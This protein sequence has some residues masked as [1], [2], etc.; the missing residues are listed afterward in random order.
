M[1]L[2]ARKRMMNLRNKVVKMF[3]LC[4]MEPVSHL[5]VTL[6]E[7]KDQCNVKFCPMGMFKCP[8]SR[9]HACTEVTVEMWGKVF[10]IK[11][12]DDGR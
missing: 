12:E 10:G 1:R 3:V 7:L 5:E 2:K 11:E 9:V 8:I 4:D 6:G